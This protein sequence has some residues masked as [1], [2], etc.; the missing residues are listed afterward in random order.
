[1]SNITRERLP[2]APLV[3]DRQHM[4]SLGRILSMVLRKLDF[5]SL[6]LGDPDGRQ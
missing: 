4:N 2:N 5:D 6:R 3:Y 1:M